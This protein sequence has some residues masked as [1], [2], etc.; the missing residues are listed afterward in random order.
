MKR[1]LFVL[2]LL[3]EAFQAS[4]AQLLVAQVPVTSTNTG[5][6]WLLM[7]DG[8]TAYPAFEKTKVKDLDQREMQ[9]TLFMPSERLYRTNERRYFE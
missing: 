2:P 6:V 7:R 1:L 3:W 5:F 9:G 4:N 8:V